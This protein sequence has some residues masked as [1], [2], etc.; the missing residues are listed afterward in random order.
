M[1]RVYIG[2]DPREMAAYRV[3]E[4]S[5]I[6]NTS[7]PVSVTPLVLSRFEDS[8]LL[9]RP[10]DLRGARYDFPS[11]APSTTE[12]SISR[13]LVPLL[14][15]TGWA[16]FVDC[17]V[18]FADDI[19]KL[20]SWCDS[21]YAVMCVKHGEITVGPKSMGQQ[22]SYPR[23]LWSSVMLINCDHPANRRLSLDD[24]NRRPGRDLHAFYW[25]ADREIG[26]LP[27]EWNYLVGVDARRTEPQS[28][29]HFTLG[30]PDNGAAPQ[31][32][33]RIWWESHAHLDLSTVD[34]QAA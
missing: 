2:Q 20:F 34:F 16:L 9:H 7:V 27:R 10:T 19:S 5:L 6:R 8:G 21:S 32:E 28:L 15:H 30:T 18:V 13:F 4:S 12:F 24:I 29:Y 33:D 1:R 14:A 3:A 17:D 25:L 31:T 11:N 22:T 23:K 26:A